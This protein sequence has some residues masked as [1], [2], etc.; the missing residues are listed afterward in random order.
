MDLS[1]DIKTLVVQHVCRIN[2]M[3]REAGA[4]FNAKHCAAWADTLSQ[5][6]IE[7]LWLIA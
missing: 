6:A 5:G 4:L 2:A 7:E 3:R 1:V